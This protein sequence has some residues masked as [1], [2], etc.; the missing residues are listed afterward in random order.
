VKRVISLSLSASLFAFTTS[1]FASDEVTLECQKATADEISSASIETNSLTTVLS[2]K[3]FVAQEEPVQEEVV[4]EAEENEAVEE[5]SAPEVALAEEPAVTMLPMMGD[6]PVEITVTD[7]TVKDGQ[8]YYLKKCKKCHGNGT[9][10]ASMHTQGEWADLFNGF[11]KGQSE[12]MYQHK[13]TKVEKFFD[14]E[15]FINKYAVPLRDFL[16]NYGNDSG[17]VPSCG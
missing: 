4:A 2:C 13:G 17:N 14:D 3:T 9:V 6:E 8:K 15:K 5:E 7:K 11:E 16:Y 12:I 10:G 1:L